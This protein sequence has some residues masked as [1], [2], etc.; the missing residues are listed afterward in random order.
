MRKLFIVLVLLIFVSTSHA[1]MR[2]FSD[3]TERWYQGYDDTTKGMTNE[4]T[5]NYFGINKIAPTCELDIDGTVSA[6]TMNC[7]NLTAD[8]L[9]QDLDATGFDITAIQDINASGTIT[10]NEFIGDLTGDITGTANNAI[11]SNYSLDS[12]KLDGEDSTYFTN[13]SNLASG[14]L[15]DARITGEY[16]FTTLNLTDLLVTNI[17]ADFD[18]T[19]FDITS[20]EDIN[21]GGTITANE[22]MGNGSGL[23][24]I[25]TAPDNIVSVISGATEITG[26]IYSTWASADAYIQTQSPS[27][28]D[29]WGIKITGTNT[30]DIV[31]RSWIRILGESST[32]I[33]TGNITS[34]VTYIGTNLFEAIVNNCIIT[35]LTIGT[36][37]TLLAVNSF[38]EGGTLSATS[39]F[40]GANTSILDGD[41]SNSAVTELFYGYVLGGTFGS[42]LK[43]QNLYIVQVKSAI[44]ISGGLFYDCRLTSGTYNSGN[45]VM[46]GGLL[47]V[48]ITLA[49]G[50]TSYLDNVSVGYTGQTITLT[51]GTLN[52]YGIAKNLTVTVTS[53]TWNNEGVKYDNAVS[54]LTATD[55]QA[56]IDEIISGFG[57]LPNT[58][59]TINFSSAVTLN[60]A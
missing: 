26:E 58:V 38:I 46:Y 8:N 3:Y 6:N 42:K 36:G 39:Y 23:T 27:T 29:R 14:T 57:G 13:A 12:D 5:N 34:A 48:N 33:L 11:T 53:G 43:G 31:V 19:G 10:A 1:I 21:A 20:I 17:E 2:K 9:E 24:G 30:E 7:T 60:N 50:T 55:T 25:Y 28:T 54:G 49:S 51:G 40:M 35:N 45:Y 16:T 32:T 18:M 59:V 22:F 47:D 52:T 56:A 15:P 4:P 41:Y 37:K 44:S